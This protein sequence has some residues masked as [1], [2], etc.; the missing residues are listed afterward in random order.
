ML[1]FSQNDFMN[2]GY[3]NTQGLHYYDYVNLLNRAI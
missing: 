2:Y 1:P 3:I